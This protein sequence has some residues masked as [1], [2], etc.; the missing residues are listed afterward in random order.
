MISAPLVLP[1]H[2]LN[3]NACMS[4][5]GSASINWEVEEQGVAGYSIEK[6][7]DGAVFSTIGRVEALG[8]GRHAYSFTE[9]EKLTGTAYFRIKQVDQNGTA[10]Y[11]RI[12]SLHTGSSPMSLY[13]N[14]T[15]DLV[16]VSISNA[17]LNQHAV[18][19]NCYG[20][21]LQTIKIEGSP[22]TVNLASY[23]SGMYFIKVGP[24]N[25]VRV[26]KE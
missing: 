21:V 9:T 22:V 24:E 18:V 19:T 2:W 16:T 4:N 1:L 12:L 20:Q 15:K 3:V 8:N 17:S 13:P 14:P 26:I 11:S 7:T 25:P 23:P 10:T 5:A 6:S